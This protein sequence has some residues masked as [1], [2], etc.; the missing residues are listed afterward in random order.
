[1]RVLLVESD[2]TAV[3]ALSAFLRAEGA[4]VETVDTGEQALELLRYYD[5]D[6]VLLNLVLPDMD[7]C[8]VIRRMRTARI[9]VP[10]LALSGPSGTQPRVAALAAGAD[11]VVA[12]LIDQPELLA[13]MRA[14]I[15]RSCGHSQP[16]L[17]VG[18]LTLNLE[19]H[20]V[21]VGSTSVQMTGKELGILQ[22]LMMRKNMVLTKEAI[23]SSLY[24]GM[25][26]PELKIIDVFICKMRKKLAA[27]G[28]PNVIG[29][30]WGRGYSIRDTASDRY[31]SP[32]PRTQ[33][34]VQ[35]Q[36]VTSSRRE[37]SKG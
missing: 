3:T 13:R 35:H 24:G 28:A 25:D 16:T 22:I 8:Q 31:T 26:E 32:A 33:M 19:T 23:L 36:I 7:G 30:V 10:V 2:S 18:A 20:Q 14:I 1:M 15:R 4:R 29:T 34:P 37:N 6:V 27:A 11:D 5:F 21:A 12:R 9:A 17:S